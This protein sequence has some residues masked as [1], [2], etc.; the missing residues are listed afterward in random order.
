MEGDPASDPLEGVLL[1]ALR[2]GGPAGPSFIYTARPTLSAQRLN[3]ARGGG[4][5]GPALVGGAGGS[6]ATFRCE[7][8][9]RRGAG[10]FRPGRGGPRSLEV[11]RGTPRSAA[12]PRP[13]F[14]V[15]A[16]SVGPA[17]VINNVETL[18]AIPHDRRPGAAPPSPRSATS[19][20]PGERRCFG[21]SGPIRRPGCG[22]RVKNGRHA[23]SVWC[24]RDPRRREPR[25]PAPLQGGAGRAAPSGSVRAGR[26]LRCRPMEAP[27]GEL[28][29]GTGGIVAV[30][31]GASIIDNRQDRCFAFN[32][33]RVVRQM[34][35]VP[36][37]GCPACSRS[38][39]RAT[40][41]RRS[42]SLGEDDPSSRSLCGLGQ[43]GA[44]SRCRKG[45]R[46]ASAT[47][48]AA[49]G[50]ERSPGRGRR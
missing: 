30:P 32:A 2:S 17:H 38:S 41:S 11:D 35:A 49:R 37:R 22:R 18:S 1:A 12:K 13:P 44:G 6:E 42:A 20:G 5:R 45:V 26:A 29:P 50:D 27:A 47:S 7:V 19:S 31:A 16:G 9:V 46:G 33:A 28:S 21:L 3:W 39:T 40:A 43:A 48:C 25:R 14:P 4:S 15:E 8:E 10:R 36:G 24:W 23:E 34:Y